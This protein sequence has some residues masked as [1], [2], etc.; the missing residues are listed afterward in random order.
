MAMVVCGGGG[1][2]TWRERFA[3]WRSSAGIGRHVSRVYTEATGYMHVVWWR[4]LRGAR[5]KAPLHYR[6]I[7][8]GARMHWRRRFQRT[9]VFAFGPRGWKAAGS[10]DADL[11]SRGIWYD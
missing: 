9:D 5:H 4:P 1:V 2:M 11:R 10:G 7:E 8:C 6:E 3:L